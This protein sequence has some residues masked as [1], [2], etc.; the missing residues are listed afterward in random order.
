M[1]LFGFILYGTLCTSW[2]WLTISFP[3]LGN[4]STI[5][6][7]QSFIHVQ[8]FVTQWTAAHQASLS[9]TNSQSL[10]KLNYYLF[11]LSLIPFLFLFFFWDP[12]NLNVGAFKIVPEIS[13]TMLSSF[14]SFYFILLFS[15]YFHTI[16]SSSSLIH[17]SASEILLLIPSR[18][19]FGDGNGNL[20]QHSCLENPMGRGA[21]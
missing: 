21:W 15:S 17:S 10:L 18:V 20:L 9:I 8:L 2:T 1:F 19:F 13:E 5:S 14:H 6:S 4:F 12:Y 3:M 11:K 7:V 16:L